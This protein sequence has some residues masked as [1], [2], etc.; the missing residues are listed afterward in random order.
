MS[1]KLKILFLSAEV[2]P[3]AKTGG[4]GDVGGS[5]PKALH[6]LGHEVRVV[7]PA[8]QKIEAGFPGVTPMA[9]A[10]TV[11]TGVGQLLAGVFQGTLPN[12][13]V[14]IYFIAEGNLFNR[15]SLYGYGDDAYRFAFFSRAA[16]ELTLA[17]DWKPDI[18]HAHDWHTAPALTWL[19]T[20]GQGSEHFRGIA[21]VFTIHN[22][23]HQGKT[24]WRI[25]DYLGLQTHALAEE[26]YDEVNFMARGIYH[27]TMINTVSPTYAQ[28]I[29]T[30]AGGA[31]LDKLLR[32]RHFDVH[33]ILNG[34]DYDEWDP[35]ADGR[36]ASHFDAEHLKKRLHNRH[37]LQSRANL[38]QR[39]NIPLVAM[40][41]RLDWQKGL[42]ITGH[43][44][45]LLM[46]GFSGDAQFIVLGTGDPAYEEM[47]ARLAAYHPEKMT[48]YLS[49]DAN[50]APLIYAGSDMFLMPSLFEPCGLGQLIA[51][52]Y[53]SV[54]VV[55]ATG[56][57][58]DTVEDGETGFLFHDYNADAFWQAL[59]RAIY[60]YN[61]DKPRWQAIQ[62]KGMMS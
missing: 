9:G 53:G 37:A 23:A 17:L 58:A 56:G 61:V 62:K 14:P 6:D 22:L 7:M 54:P 44:I 46:N 11:P 25:F 41:S 36:L 39:D 19:S 32:H 10:L 45:H 35:V 47:F 60:V 31:G 38:P 2:A 27:A 34:L 40:V 33:G 48:A 15:P 21:S 4:L 12:S 55:R 49:Y 28:E 13:E 24:N 29:M 43:V 20:A 26:G 5:L 18:V 57:L 50:F 1:D 8:Y 51:M 52:R 16:L 42:D 3:F 30:P 59:Q